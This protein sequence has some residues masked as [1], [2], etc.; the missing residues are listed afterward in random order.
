MRLFEFIDDDSLRLKLTAMCVELRAD[1][2]KTGKIL[3]TDE[4]VQKLTSLGIPIE[5]S[6]LFDMVKKEPLKNFIADI[7]GENVI[8]KGQKGAEEADDQDKQEKIVKDMATKA[9]K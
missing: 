4:F 9:L 6:D 7:S 2:L 5:T 3:T 8:F 1:A